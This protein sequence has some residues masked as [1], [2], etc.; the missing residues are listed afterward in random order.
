QYYF[1]LEL[2]SNFDIDGI[3]SVGKPYFYSLSVQGFPAGKYKEDYCSIQTSSS[4][5]FEPTPTIYTLNIDEDYTLDYDENGTAYILFFRP[6]ANLS[7]YTDSQN[8]IMIDYRVNHEFIQDYDYYIKENPKDPYT[9]Q[10]E[11]DYSYTDYDTFHVHPDFADE[12]YF[13][14]EYSALEWEIFNAQYIHDGEDAFIFQPR[15]YYNLSILYTGEV[16]TDEFSVQYIVPADQYEEDYILFKRIFVLAQLG[17]DEE[18]MKVFEIPNYESTS[19]LYQNAPDSYNYTIAFNE[20]ETYIQNTYNPS[21]QLVKNSYIYVLAKYDSVLLRYPMGHTPFNYEYLGENH[22]AYQIALYID[23][24]LT[25]YSNESEFHDYVL[26]IEDN[27]IYFNNKSSGQPG[28]IAPQSEIKLQYK[29][30]L[31]P[32]LLD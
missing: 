16:S 31:Q 28:Y 26:K 9:S 1:G 11:W 20:I 17:T 22:D 21:Y 25:T 14:V 19:Y 18:T 8:K 12:T 3:R 7:S 15:E 2:T 6:V 13:T 23:G 24:V 32:G 5:D 30:K 4:G 27:Y 29:F 10:I